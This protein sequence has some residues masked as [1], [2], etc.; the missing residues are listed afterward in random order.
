MIGGYYHAIYGPIE[1]RPPS[2]WLDAALFVEWIVKTATFPIWIVLFAWLF[3][4]QIYRR[5]GSIVSRTLIGT[6]SFKNVFGT[7]GIIGFF[8]T[9]FVY[10]GIVFLLIYEG[11]RSMW[12]R[13]TG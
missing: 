4:A 6:D 9:F 3:I 10:W 11:L 5:Q 1:P 8:L 12:R 13:M 2:I 7:L